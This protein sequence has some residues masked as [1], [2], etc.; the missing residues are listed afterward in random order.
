MTK[1]YHINS[2]NGMIGTATMALTIGLLV[3]VGLKFWPSDTR[4]QVTHLQLK[5]ETPQERNGCAIASVRSKSRWFGPA[6]EAGNQKF[7]HLSNTGFFAENGDFMLAD[8]SVIPAKASDV[9]GMIPKDRILHSCV[10]SQRGYA[11]CKAW[12]AW[13]NS[14]ANN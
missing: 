3:Y 14:V 5:Y 8:L 9:Y 2:V 12:A 10:D 1:S 13:W 11:N 6:D 4:A 7:C